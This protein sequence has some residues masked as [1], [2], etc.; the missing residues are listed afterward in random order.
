M[1]AGALAVVI[2]D[3]GSC[4]EDFNCGARLGSRAAGGG[5]AADDGQRAWAD[6]DVPVVLISAR[7]A[8]RLEAQLDLRV[9]TVDG[10]SHR[11]VRD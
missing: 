5:L 4:G 1:Q 11:Y 7:A 2:A 9:A 6:V 10:S 3:D 8:A